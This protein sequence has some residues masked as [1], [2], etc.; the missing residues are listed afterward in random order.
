MVNN[1]HKIDLAKYNVRSDLI[2]ESGIKD[3]ISESYNENNIDVSYIKLNKKM[4]TKA[5][6][7]NYL[8]ILKYLY[9]KFIS[10]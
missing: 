7:K 2:I 4:P 5:F 6:S 1:M 9:Y 8:K 3:Y 10:F